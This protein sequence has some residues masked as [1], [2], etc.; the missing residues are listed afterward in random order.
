MH[1]RLS[2]Y[3]SKRLIDRAGGHRRQ[4]LKAFEEKCRFD[5]LDEELRLRCQDERLAELL[6]HARQ[7]VPHFQALMAGWDAIVPENAREALSFL[8][9]MTR[10][11]IQSDPAVHTADI[12]DASF[13]D[14]TGGSTGTPMRFLVDRATQ[15]ARESSLYWSDRLAGW[16]YG[17]RIAMLWGSDRDVKSVTENVRSA[18]RWWLENRRW[19]NTFNMSVERMDAFHQD[20]CR[21]RPHVIIAYAGA[22]ER[23]ARYLRDRNTDLNYPLRSIISS[24]EMLTP[25]AR[26]IVKDVFGQ[27][28][29]D[30]YGNREFGAIAAECSRQN[31]LHIN[32]MDCIVEIDSPDSQVEPGC[33]RITHLRNKVMPF[34]RYDTG[35]L[36]CRAPD[37]PCACGC[38]TTRLARICGRQADSIRTQTGGMIHGEFITHLLYSARRVLEFQFIQESRTRY[39]LLLVADGHEDDETVDE[40]RKGIKEV[41]G[42]DSELDIRYVETIPATASGKRKFILSRL[43][44]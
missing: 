39:T 26:E 43:R 40:W 23:Y 21:F 35:D 32:E 9:V 19:Y 34:I 42:P 25:A 27:P 13:Q 10:S 16:R 44:D 30:R 20:L 6:N 4:V 15:V 41:T 1:P 31:G 38:R 7:H 5:R 14:A 33:V 36:A 12:G 2:S 29:Y 22:M 17:D 18:V 8:P 11:D 24:A 37:E 28:V 3:L